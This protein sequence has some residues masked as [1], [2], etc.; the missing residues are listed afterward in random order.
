MM[1]LLRRKRKTFQTNL[2]QETKLND[3]AVAQTS[4]GLI[5]PTIVDAGRLL[6]TR[7]SLAATESGN[8][9]QQG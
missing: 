9:K 1:E 2:Q 4:F 6:A 3:L 7:R 5:L 8:G